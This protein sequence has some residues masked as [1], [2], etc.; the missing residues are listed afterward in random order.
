MSP[1]RGCSAGCSTRWPRRWGC[2]AAARAGL[3]RLCPCRRQATVKPRPIADAMIRGI[4]CSSMPQVDHDNPLELEETPGDY[5]PRPDNRPRMPE[6]LPVKLVAVEDVTMVAPAGIA[7]R[8]DEF[9]VGLFGFERLG[10]V[11]ELLY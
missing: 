7:P 9:Y 1:G 2:G 8:L 11:S 5:Q 3:G 6:P 4:D 10:R